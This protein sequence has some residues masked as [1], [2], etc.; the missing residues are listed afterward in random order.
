MRRHLLFAPVVFVVA[1]AIAACA[2]TDAGAPLMPGSVNAPPPPLVLTGDA[3][4]TGTTWAWRETVMSNDKRIKP[5]APERYTL[6]FQPGGAV[7]VRADCNRGSGR[8]E[9]NGG[10]LSFGPMAVTRAMCPPDS[11][12]SEFM[13]EIGAVSGQLFKGDELVL[14][15]KL[16]SGSMFFTTTR[17]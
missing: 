14:T 16:D 15:L 6:L 2:S 12:D 10:S 3:L 5:D 7:A 9:L 1:L 11:M 17:Q 4:L 13:K 8:Y